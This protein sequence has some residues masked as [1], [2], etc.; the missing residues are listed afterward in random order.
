MDNKTINSIPLRLVILFTLALLCQNG[1]AAFYSLQNNSI[2][3]IPERPNVLWKS[4]IMINVDSLQR[5]DSL[6]LFLDNET[7][8]IQLNYSSYTTMGYYAHFSS[9]NNAANAYISIFESSINGYIT[10]NSSSYAIISTSLNQVEISKYI[11]EE[12]NDDTAQMEE[13]RGMSIESEDEKMVSAVQSSVTPVIRILFLYTNSVF[14]SIA[15]I[16]LLPTNIMLFLLASASIERANESFSN[17]DIDARLELAYLGPTNY[18]ESNHNWSSVLQ[19]FY[20]NNDGYIDEVHS[21]RNK[22]SADVCVLF[23]NK[24][25][26]CGEAKTI[27]AEPNTAFCIVHPGTGCIQTFSVAHE[28]GH[29]IGCRHNY[30]HDANIVPYMYGHGYY[31]YEANN[32]DASWRTIMSY[33]NSCPNGCQPILYWSNPD[34]YY[35]GLPTGTS[36]IAHNARVWNE[37][38]GTVSVFKN[39]QDTI[40]YTAADNNTAA[41][42]E[43]IKATTQIYT[44]GGFEIQSGQIVIMNTAYSITLGPNTHIKN[45][46]IFQASVGDLDNPNNLPPRIKNT[47]NDVVVESM[48]CNDEDYHSAVHKFLRDGQLLIEKDGHTYNAQGI[49]VE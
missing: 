42:F 43:S 27:K 37:R 8:D 10:T 23:L 46:A 38:A 49:K 13:T 34:V 29:L 21:L 9:T 11:I 28:I 25:D 20:Q 22:Y 3:D 15:E 32:T 4:S 36:S 6:R 47:D 7:V 14:D 12:R 24:R 33:D 26:K 48:T 2:M 45:G 35:N 1:F 41:I 18:N 16:S 44:G 40:N 31:H 17:S 39:E 5:S 30:S 19:H